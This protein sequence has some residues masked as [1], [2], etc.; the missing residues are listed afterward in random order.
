MDV[1]YTALV[2]AIALV[3]VGQ[4]TD[5]SS[6]ADKQSEPNLTSAKDTDMLSSTA[7]RQGGNAQPSNSYIPEVSL[8][9]SMP[10]TVIKLTSFGARLGHKVHV[11]ISLLT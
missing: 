10:C 3:S 1:T 6:H 9:V 2:I 7:Q 11:E 8:L 4:Q 5:P